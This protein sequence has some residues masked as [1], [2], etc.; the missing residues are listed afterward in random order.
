[1]RISLE[2]DYA[3]R[4]VQCLVNE[5]KRMDAE[6]IAKATGVTK[7]F[8]F[9]ILHKLVS[10]SLVKSY[11]GIGGGYELNRPGEEITLKEV[12]ETIEGPIVLSRCQQDDYYC[13]H[14]DECTCYFHKVF[15]DIS[16]EIIHRLEKVNFGVKRN[17]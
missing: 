17:S 4:I 10:A 14:R 8:T 2:A 1:M 3:I 5:G 16:N 15:N 11:K 9:K 7:R 6:S 13:D 12:I